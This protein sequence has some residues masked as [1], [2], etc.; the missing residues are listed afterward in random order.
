MM[1]PGEVGSI[2][3]IDFCGSITRLSPSERLEFGRGAALD[4]DET[5]R[6]LH[7]RLGVLFARDGLWMLSNIGRTIPIQILDRASRSSVV[8]ASGTETPI[9]YRDAVVR[10]EAG[11]TTYELDLCQ[12][13]LQPSMSRVAESSDTI[14]GEELPITLEQRL[15]IV[16]LSEPSLANPIATFQVPTNREA[17]LRL[18]WKITKYNRKLDNV[19]DRLSKAGVRGLHAGN[20]VVASDRRQRLVRFAISSGLVTQND[21]ALLD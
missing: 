19:C 5:N 17:A 7:R 6:F 10:F 15:L 18:G 2:L 11:P 21:L 13:L 3:E 14:T 12:P 1:S 20:G 9:G 8:L 16:A 4:I